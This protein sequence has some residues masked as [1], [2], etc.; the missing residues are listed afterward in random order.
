[1]GTASWVMVG[2]NVNEELSFGS[3]A[4][5]AG[6]YLSRAAAKRTYR[7]GQL[8]SELERSGI[9]LRAASRETVTEEAPEAYKNVDLV[10]EA[11]HNVGLAKK[12]VRM[13]PIG[14]V[15]G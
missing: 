13:R 10:A 3:A 11:T 5:G 15:K 14:V 6:R 12:V 2:Q 8:V 4:H 1:M 7:Y 9:M